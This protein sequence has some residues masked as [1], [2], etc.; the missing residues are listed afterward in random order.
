MVQYKM[1]EH[2]PGEHA[3]EWIFR[4]NRQFDNQVAKMKNLNLCNSPTENEYRINPQP[5][6]L[7]F[8]RRDV[9]LGRNT[10]TI[11]IDHYEA[12][13][14][15]PEFRGP[16]GGIRVSY[17]SLD[18]RYL[19]QKSFIELVSSGYIG[20]HAKSTAELKDIIESILKDRKSVVAA[21][22]AKWNK[23]KKEFFLV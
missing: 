10:V 13:L 18:G 20:S 4:P 7:R 14:K 9:N 19:R 22:Q 12:L 2:E 11:P 3:D 16:R 23:E 6:Y 1:L 21:V 17:R 5:F 15:N 8:V